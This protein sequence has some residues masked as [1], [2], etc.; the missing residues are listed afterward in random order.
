M[1]CSRTCGAWRSSATLSYDGAV[2]EIGEVQAAAAKL[3]LDAD[4]LEIRHAGD[5]VPAFETLKSGTQALYVCPD[6]LVNANHARINT[7]ALGRASPRCT[8]S[9]NL[10]EQAASCPTGPAPLTYSGAQ[11]T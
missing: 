2:R 1:S 11:A 6:A 5:V 3:G 8:P 7:L 4:A 9:A 10:S